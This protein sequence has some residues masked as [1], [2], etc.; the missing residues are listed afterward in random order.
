MSAQLGLALL[1]LAG[2]LLDFYFLIKSNVNGIVKENKKD[3][4]YEI[5]QRARAGEVAAL[6]ELETMAAQG[7]SKAQFHLGML[8][9]KGQGVTQNYVNALKWLILAKGNGEGPLYEITEVRREASH[10][11]F[12]TALEAA[13]LWWEE[14]RSKHK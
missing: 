12:V 11:Q 10:F 2:M 14:W 5:A 6:Q 1:L 4:F 8:Y 9:Y 13:L 7:V 3:P